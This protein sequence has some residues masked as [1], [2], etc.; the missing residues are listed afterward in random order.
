MTLTEK[1][2][3]LPSSPGCYIYKDATGKV[4]YVG[5]AKL[6]RNRVRQYFQSSR[7]IDVKTAEM[8]TRIADLEYIVTDN[9]VEAL[10]LE[11]NLIK[12]HGHASM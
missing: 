3:T 5:K 2:E 12:R 4:I 1:L 10:V 7:N 9:E 8:V 11:S 6:L